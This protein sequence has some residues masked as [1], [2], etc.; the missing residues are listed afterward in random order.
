MCTFTDK[1]ENDEMKKKYG[2]VFAKMF[3][4]ADTNEVNMQQVLQLVADLPDAIKGMPLKAL[5][6]LVPALQAA[7][8]MGKTEIVAEGGE[9][10]GAEGGAPGGEGE[11]RSVT[12]QVED[13]PPTAEEKQQMADAEALKFSDAVKVAADELGKVYVSVIAKAKQFLPDTY[14]FSD[15]TPETIMSDAIATTTDDKFEDAELST[16]FKLLKHSADYKKF[17]D[18]RTPGL[19]E[20]IGDKTL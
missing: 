18:A 5:Q 8:N 14:D 16:A 17:G 4:D 1:E 2:A 19:V 13:E 20:S 3:V 15:K 6:K 7:V 10:P 9:V 12:Q 11:Q